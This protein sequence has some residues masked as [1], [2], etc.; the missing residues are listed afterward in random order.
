LTLNSDFARLQFS[1]ISAS[2]QQFS[3][4]VSNSVLIFKFQIRLAIIRTVDTIITK[5]TGRPPKIPIFIQDKGDFTSCASNIRLL[6]V[7]PTQTSAQ[8]SAEGTNN[9]GTSPTPIPET[10]QNHLNLFICDYHVTPL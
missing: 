5:I 3:R 2:C 10:N 6:G 8:C 9:A 4:V 7:S 1:V